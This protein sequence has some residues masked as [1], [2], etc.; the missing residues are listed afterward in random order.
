VEVPPP[1]FE[2]EI[3]LARSGQCADALRSIEAALTSD[4]EPASRAAPSAAA[5]AEIARQA[6]TSGD[7]ATAER[8]LEVALRLCPHYADLH[9]QRARLLLGLNRRLE[10]RHALDEA[11]RQNPRYRAARLERALLD[12]R[13]GRITDALAALHE[14][15]REVPAEEADGFQRGIERLE[16]ADWE[17]AEPLLKR[18]ID[19]SGPDLRPLLERVRRYLEVGEAASAVQLLRQILPKHEG[20]PDLHYL[21]GLSELKLGHFDDALGSLARALE[22]NPD[23]HD[24]RVQFACALEC[25]GETA[26]A[27]KQL[28]LVLECEPSHRRALELKATWSD[29]G[30]GD[31]AR[32]MAARDAPQGGQA[33]EKPAA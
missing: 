18:A 9:F 24:A 16:R 26:H 22:L 14:L 13:E 23:F 25:V 6:E 5:L 4:P 12:A 30:G 27:A 29:R 20:Y 1:E 21:A 11:V 17:E 33:E 28:A 19:S 31:H 8:A 10:A 32:F 2:H 15:A 7:P 3:R